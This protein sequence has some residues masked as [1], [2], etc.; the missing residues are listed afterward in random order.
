[1]PILVRASSRSEAEILPAK[2]QAGDLEFEV[3][4]GHEFALG[5]G[6]RSLRSDARLPEGPTRCSWEDLPRAIDFR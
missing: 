1:M 3:Q 6:I 5:M 2:P 4:R